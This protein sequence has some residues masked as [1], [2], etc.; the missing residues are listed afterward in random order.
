MSYV[1]TLPGHVSPREGMQLGLLVGAG[2]EAPRDDAF[3]V[4]LRFVRA[5]GRGPVG[6]PR[7]RHGGAANQTVLEVGSTQTKQ[8]NKQREY[9]NSTESNN[10]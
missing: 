3:E 1:G 4:I 6:V 5:I 9:N 10:K 2:G 7:R 8:W